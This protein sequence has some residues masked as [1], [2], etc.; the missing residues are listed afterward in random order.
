MIVFQTQELSSSITIEG[1][2]IDNGHNGND[3]Q[4]FL[5]AIYSY[6]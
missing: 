2:I 6:T 1:T 4:T 5:E 3:F